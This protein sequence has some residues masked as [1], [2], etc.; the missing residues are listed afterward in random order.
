MRKG[1]GWT[2]T[3]THI[4]CTKDDSSDSS[5]RHVVHHK[6][7]EEYDFHYCQM[8]LH[9]QDKCGCACSNTQMMTTYNGQTVGPDL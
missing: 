2:S 6:N 7:K 3:C 4:Y 8:H 1:K 5:L 9:Q